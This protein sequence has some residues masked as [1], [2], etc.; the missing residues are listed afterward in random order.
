MNKFTDITKIDWEILN[1]LSDDY[2]SV[3]QIQNLIESSGSIGHEKKNILDRLEYLH[4]RNYVFLI[5]NQSFKREELNKEIEGNTEDRQFWFGRTENGYL[6]WQELNSTYLKNQK[7][8]PVRIG[9]G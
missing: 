6:A 2:E 7:T 3:G 5:N 9:N 8:E 4:K 1:A